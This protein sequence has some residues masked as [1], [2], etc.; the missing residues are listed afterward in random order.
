MIVTSRPQS[1]QSTLARDGSLPTPEEWFGKRPGRNGFIAS[2]AL[3]AGYL[4]ALAKASDRLSIRQY[5]EDLES[6]PLLAITVTARENQLRLQELAAIQLELSCDHNRSASS[7]QGL[8]NQARGVVL[9][10]CGIHGTE[11]GAPQMVPRLIHHLAT[12]N[13]PETRRILRELVI[14]VVPSLNPSG[15]ELVRRWHE[16]TRG[17]PYDSTPPPGRFQR[18]AGHDNNRDWIAQ[19]QPEIATTVERLL[20]D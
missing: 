1:Q 2:T 14:L 18:Y 10:T 9:I 7:R 5:G 3:I 13:S 4:N 6:E 12:D 19:T 11:L 15:M 17:G 8:G 16:R 20:N